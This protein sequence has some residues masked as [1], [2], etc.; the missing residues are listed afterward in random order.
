MTRWIRFESEGIERFGTLDGDVVAE[1]EGD[2]FA[3]PAATVR[4]HSLD[5]V[6]L[7]PP[8][9][10]TK[11]VG[12]WNNFHER[13]RVEGLTRP[14]HPLYF[15][16]SNNSFTGPGARI[17]RPAGYGGQVVF[18]G[19]LGIV[20]GR[21]CSGTVPSDAI[22]GYTC[23]ND[24]TAR[25]IL[26]AD[27]SFPQWTRA[28]GYDGFGVFGPCIATG[29]RPESLRVRTWLAGDLKQDYP[30]ADMFFLPE[31]IVAHVARDMTLEPGDV[32]ACG[33]SVG[34][35]AMRDG[36]RVEV[37]VEGIGILSNVF[38]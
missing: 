27:P 25:D 36:D 21:R 6:R 8:C 5:S 35:C 33:T 10:P 38:G 22:F 24:V 19:E 3:A 34:V 28:K 17:A 14:R 20:I 1:Y 7:L 18:E 30:V 16:K 26:H 23:V 31:E 37:A 13:A 4:R 15:L 11:M 32:I 12:L 2:M 29:L 9:K